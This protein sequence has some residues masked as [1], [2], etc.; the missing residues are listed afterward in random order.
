M[1]RY[2][3]LVNFEFNRFLK[4]YLILIGITIFSQLAGVII[5]S[6]GYLEQVDYF[7]IEEQMTQ[8]EVINNYGQFSLANTT[9]SIFFVGP[10]VLCI[11]TLLIY[12]LFIW[13][14]EW[15][16]KNMFI[17]RLLMLPTERVTIYF[18]KATTIFI[19][20]FGLVA[21]QMILLVVEKEMITW[22][23]PEPFRYDSSI[24]EVTMYNF[25]SMLIPATFDEFLINYFVGMMA[26]L[27]L[28]TCVLFER[29][30]R[31]KGMIMAIL[32]GIASVAICFSPLLIDNRLGG[33]FY[34]IE[35]FILLVIT[36][37]LVVVGSV[38]TSYYLLK[39]KIT[40]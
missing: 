1:N 37:T 32:F 21:V 17:Y 29:S 20:V 23:V 27:V 2:L 35:L 34:P 7:M 38:W 6:R 4:I 14:R 16:G 31:L 28:F 24:Y 8:V 39:Y 36:S 3:K 13:Y 26:V 15:L 18:A 12:C 10:I 5:E 30:F 19:Q 22:L 9:S 11:A 25:L 33:F 40:V